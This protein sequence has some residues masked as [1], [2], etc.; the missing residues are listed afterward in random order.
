[1]DAY[2]DALNRIAEQGMSRGEDW[3]VS[4]AR[5]ALGLPGDEELVVETLARGET[6]WLTV[7][8]EGAPYLLRTLT[9]A[10]RKRDMWQAARPDLKF[11]IRTVSGE[12]VPDERG[13]TTAAADPSREGL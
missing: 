2:K 8:M 7:K 10:R 6:N 9:S 4:I 3:C 13:I 5:E 1:M 11:R 12:V